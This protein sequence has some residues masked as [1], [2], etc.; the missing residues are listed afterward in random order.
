ME[1]KLLH[2]L[3]LWIMYEVFLL[4]GLYFSAPNMHIFDIQFG[5]WVWNSLH[6]GYECVTTYC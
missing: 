2:L 4:N 3:P 6:I 1:F 5:M